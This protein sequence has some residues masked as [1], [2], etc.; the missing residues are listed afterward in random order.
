MIELLVLALA[1]LATGAV[2]GVLAGLLGVG[3]GIVI[4]PV[5]YTT[6]DVYG[7]DPSIHMQVATA[8]SLATIIATSISS[9]RSHHAKGAVDL[10]L[11][12][13]WAAAMVLGAL[14]GAA[15]AGAVV[16]DVLILVFAIVALIVALW[17]L[18][19]DEDTRLREGLPAGVAQQ[20]LPFGI[21]LLSSLMGLGAGTLGVPLLSLFAYPIHRAVGTAALFGLAIALPATIGL[22]VA[23]FGDPRLPPFSFGFVSLPGLLMVPVTIVMAP[24]GAMLAHK[25]DRRTLRRA[26]GLFLLITAAR[27]FWRLLG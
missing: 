12:R 21:G 3:G 19:G 27:F 8:T 25:L 4:V 16:S 11:A 23:G 26:F 10:D 17:M 6:L 22:V 24:L 15:I 9:A 14:A 20:G 2:A 5:L 13:R 7:I 18:I 1:M